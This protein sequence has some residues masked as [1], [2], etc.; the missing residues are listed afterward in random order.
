MAF[1]CELA[2]A[3]GLSLA[4]VARLSAAEVS[5]W[6]AFRSRYGFPADRLVWATAMGASYCGAVW[7]GKAKPDDLIPE[8][9]PVARRAAPDDI[10]AVKAWFDGRA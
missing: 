1:Q 6:R 9:D 2:L 7:G 3:L 8:F 10:A 4:G 5:V